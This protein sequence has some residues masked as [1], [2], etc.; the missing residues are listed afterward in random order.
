MII[1][2][3]LDGTVYAYPAFFAEMIR[4]MTARGHKI[5]CVSCHGIDRWNAR[6]IAELAAVGVPADLIDPSLLAPSDHDDF[7]VKGKMAD[8]CD[9]VFDDQGARLREHTKTPVW[10]M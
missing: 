8:R 6:D 2:V 9:V 10:G 3:D 7:V 4:A 5:V 1:G